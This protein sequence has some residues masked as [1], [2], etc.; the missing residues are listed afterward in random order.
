MSVKGKLTISGVSK[1]VW[2]SVACK[3]NPDESIQA[4][5]SCKLK[6]SEYNVSPPTFMFGAMKTGDEVSIK[7]NALLVK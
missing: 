3:V 7:F 1:D 5:G 6:M 4:D 2:V